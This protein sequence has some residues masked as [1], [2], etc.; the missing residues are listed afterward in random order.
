M[1]ALQGVTPTTVTETVPS[2]GINGLMIPPAEAPDVWEACCHVVPN[3]T[4]AVYRWV[5]EVGQAL[6]GSKTVND[7]FADSD[8]ETLG[9]EA[10]PATVGDFHL[11]ADEVAVSGSRMSPLSALASIDR[12]LR[13]RIQKDA[14]ALFSGASNHSNFTGAAFTVEKFI[15]ANMTFA[16]QN[17]TN[18][19]TVFVGSSGQLTQIVKN[20]VNLAGGGLVMSTGTEVFTAPKVRGYLGAFNGAEIYRSEVPAADA[21]ND[22]G[23]FISCAEIGQVIDGEWQPGCGIGVAFWW[24]PRAARQRVEERTGE[25]LVVSARYGVAITAPHNVRKV[26]TLNA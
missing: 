10:T 23:G 14:F 3:A 21:S 7:E 11:Y 5:R 18:L 22:V 25:K 8:F 2:E 9:A 15:D 13:K 20:M 12:R 17:P 6:T 26:T 24:V 4:G 16:A 1:A 19:R